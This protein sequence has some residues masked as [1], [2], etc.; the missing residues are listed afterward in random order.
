MTELLFSSSVIFFK[1]I[2]RRK[3]KIET[4]NDSFH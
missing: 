3:S 2:F 1:P 4:Y